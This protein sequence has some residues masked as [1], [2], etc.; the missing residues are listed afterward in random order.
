MDT[1]PVHPA[2]FANAKIAVAG[3]CGAVVLLYFRPETSFVRTMWLVF[4]GAVC[5]FYFTPFA[6]KVLMAM[7]WISRF[8]VGDANDAGLV[9]MLIGFLGMT[10]AKSVLRA[11]ESFDL[12][13][14]LK[15]RFTK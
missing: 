6:I 15:K 13:E 8:F 14:W 3:A 10:I 5:A 4:C 2:W 9:G 7:P 1:P 11:V 12:G